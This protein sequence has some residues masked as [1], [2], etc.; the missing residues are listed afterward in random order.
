VGMVAIYSY[1]ILSIGQILNSWT[2]TKNSLA[3]SAV[4][5]AMIV[6]NDDSKNGNNSQIGY[7]TTRTKTKTIVDL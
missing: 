7:M 3:G 6:V 4:I 1:L 2:T 5:L